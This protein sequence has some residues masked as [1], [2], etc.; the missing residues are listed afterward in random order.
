MWFPPPLLPSPSSC[1]VQWVILSGCGN[2][3][4]IYPSPPPSRW[5]L[6]ISVMAAAMVEPLWAEFTSTMY[7]SISNFILQTS[8]AGWLAMSSQVVR[9]KGRKLPLQLRMWWRPCAR[10]SP[11]TLLPPRNPSPQTS[12]GEV[13]LVTHAQ[14]VCGTEAGEASLG[15]P[16]GQGRGSHPQFPGYGCYSPG[17]LWGHERCERKTFVFWAGWFQCA[18]Q[19]SALD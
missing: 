13:M 14:C 17:L 3:Q 6:S 7:F 19:P 16:C 5:G 12:C 8:W 11:V 10:V 18:L 1:P 2:L 15:Q 4:H 9:R